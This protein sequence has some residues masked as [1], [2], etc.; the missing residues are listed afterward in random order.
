MIPTSELAPP[1][2]TN[3]VPSDTMPA[4]AVLDKAVLDTAAPETTPSGVAADRLA[5]ETLL[6]CW[7]V[8]RQLPRPDGGTLE[9]ELGDSVLLV[10]VEYWSPSGMHRLGTPRGSFGPLGTETVAWLLG[11]AADAAGEGLE[12]LVRRAVESSARIAAHLAAQTARDT[13]TDPDVPSQSTP[14]SPRSRACSPAIRCTRRRR[15]ATD[16]A[17]PRRRASPRNCTVRSR[18]TGSRS[19]RIWP[20]M[21]ANWDRARPTSPRFSAA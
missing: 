16:S 14:F 17:T 4:A 3:P 2:E 10:P 21:T 9:V 5:I 7:I 11:A 15:A 8:E 1:Q 12:S 18:C 20:R 6:R 13:A 19:R